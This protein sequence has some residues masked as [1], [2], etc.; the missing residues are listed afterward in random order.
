MLRGNVLR[1]AHMRWV[2]GRRFAG[3]HPA[4][5]ARDDNVEVSLP[6][7]KGYVVR[8]TTTVQKTAGRDPSMRQHLSTS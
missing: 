5:L 3:L 8:M 6:W 7:S 4:S 1:F 2:P